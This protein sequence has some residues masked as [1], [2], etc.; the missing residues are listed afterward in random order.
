MAIPDYEALMLPVLRIAADRKENCAVPMFPSPDEARLSYYKNSYSLAA[1]SLT[2]TTRMPITAVST[3]R[4]ASC[5]A[6]AAGPGLRGDPW[7]PI[8]EFW[9]HLVREEA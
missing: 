3:A 1:K 8:L 9:H 4:R 6:R 7:L 5:C 2:R